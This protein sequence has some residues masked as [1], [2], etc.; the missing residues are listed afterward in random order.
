MSAESLPDARLP[1]AALAGVI[2]S[3][4]V[5]GV[6][7]GLSYP[8]FT[9][10]MQ[11]QGMSSGAIGL[12]AAMTPLGLM[13]SALFVPALVRLLGA[14]GLA[15][16]C[17]TAAATLFLFVGLTQNWL[18]WYPARF[19]IGLAVNPLYI[20]GEV[21]LIALAPAARRGRILG[22]FNAIT[23]AGYAAGPLTLA[24]LGTDGW[25]P[26]MVGI[27][28]FLGCAL[29]LY[30]T[31]NRLSSFDD[32]GR[33]GGVLHFWLI[34]PALML[35]VVVSA[36]TQQS[37]YSLLPVFGAGYH[38]P[39]T[40]IA[41]LVGIMSIGNIVLQIPLGLLAE[42]VGGRK[43][44]IA[45]AAA[46]LCGALLMPLLVTTPLQWPLLLIMGGVGYGVYTMALVELG[47]RFSGSA[48]VAGN[49]AFGLMW[50]LGGIIG[51]PGSGLFMQFAGPVGLPAVIATLSAI[52][53]LFATVRSLMA[54]RGQGLQ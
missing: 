33:H 11:K 30:L 39:E 15:V 13:T 47:N 5:F 48:L 26:L 35:A 16:G 2:A 12:S 22:V 21:W 29:I 14:R 27:L 40:T 7:Q 18:A 46:N 43:M 37:I 50:G 38:M 49:A 17:A 25:P 6:A 42:R 52:L 19:L 41:T 9:F 28:G 8:L 20:L 24:V 44:I 45:C 36:A 31:A 4:T 51:P 23:G 34:A 53:V 10:L 3:V 32:G 1:V 54:R